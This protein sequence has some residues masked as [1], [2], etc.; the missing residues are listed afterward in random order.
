MVTNNDGWYDRESG[1][2]S[3]EQDDFPLIAS[4]SYLNSAGLGL[5]PLK[6]QKKVQKYMQA[7][8]TRGTFGYFEYYEELMNGAIASAAELWG[9]PARNVA[10]ATSVSEAVSQVAWWRKPRRGENVVLIC[11]DSSAAT[12]SWLRV[13]ED[14]GAEVRFAS[15]QNGS[16]VVTTRDVM[17][18]IDKNTAAVCIS[19][20]HW[21]TGYRLDLTRLGQMVRDHDALLIVDATHSAGIVNYTPEELKAVDMLVTGSFKWLL[22]LAGAAPLYVGD[23][24]LG[25]FN[26]ILVGSRTSQPLPPFDQTDPTRINLPNDARRFEYGSS[27]AVPRIA[28]TASIK[29]LSDVGRD[30]ILQHIQSLGSELA[31][32]L[33]RE[34]AE[35]ITPSAHQKRAGIISAYFPDHSSKVIYKALLSNNV[36]A[37]LRSRFLRFSPHIFNTEKDIFTA[38]DVIKTVLGRA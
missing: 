35:V 5:V 30:K 32:R 8:G 23:R 26:P 34:G 7:L 15:P 22:G 27:I 33:I 31:E 25:D 20:V 36:A 1:S 14:T 3:V 2:L 18:L 6:V 11:D 24:L 13:A 37:S 17:A 38:I 9:A 28:F 21:I 29:Y 16:D 12:Y 10:V 4:V 19:H